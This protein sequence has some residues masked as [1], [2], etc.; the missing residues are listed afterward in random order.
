MSRGI[1][2]NTWCNS[3]IR[4]S[5]YRGTGIWEKDTHTHPLNHV[6]PGC[7]HTCL[8]LA[9]LRW[10]SRVRRA[11]LLHRKAERHLVSLV[12]I[13]SVFVSIRCHGN[14]TFRIRRLETS[15]FT[16]ARDAG[17]FCVSQEEQLGSCEESFSHAVPT[18]AKTSLLNTLWH[19]EK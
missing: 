2:K 5:I 11:A 9:L 17:L 12:R 10:F 3:Q 15:I 1:P 6:P 13:N 8:V 19:G 18:C 16:A 4:T 14:A 7:G